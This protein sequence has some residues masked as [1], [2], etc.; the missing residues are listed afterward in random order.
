VTRTVGELCAELGWT[1]LCG[2][3]DR[4]VAGAYACDM[5]SWAMA[6]ARSG[7]A[8]ITILNSLNVIAVA[9]LAEVGCVVVAENAGMAAEVLERARE[10]GVAVVSAPVDTCRA[11]LLLH[12]AGIV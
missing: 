2:D 3:A 9:H 8:W 4:P 1:L 11:I 12:A 5:L 7:V 6:R 10:K